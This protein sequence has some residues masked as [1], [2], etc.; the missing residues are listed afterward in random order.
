MIFSSSSEVS[1][2]S[3][4]RCC[5]CSGS[6]EREGIV[7]VGPPV[8][9]RERSD[10]SWRE[11]AAPCF[12]AMADRFTDRSRERALACER[13]CFELLLLLLL[14]DGRAQQI[15]V[16]DPWKCQVC[17]GSCLLGAPKGCHSME[18]QSFAPFLDVSFLFWGFRSLSSSY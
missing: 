11:R 4:R 7:E 5:C 12:M 1:L 14:A 17:F 15:P 10:A 6:L 8:R 3:D 18:I 9:R 16:F 2:E 13:K